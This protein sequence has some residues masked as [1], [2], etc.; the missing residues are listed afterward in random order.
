LRTQ[1]ADPKNVASIILGGGAGT[2]L[3]PLTSKR[4]KPAVRIVLF[5]H[6]FLWFIV[7]EV[8][9]LLII[10]GANW[11]VLQ[12]DRYTDEQLHQQWY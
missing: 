2:R 6:C 10:V 7:N 4:A 8:L 1:N 9:N 11:R 3:F 5:V 12:A